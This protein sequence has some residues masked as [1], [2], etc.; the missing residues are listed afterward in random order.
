MY[1]EAEIG[2]RRGW[3]QDLWEPAGV[4]ADEADVQ[5]D[6]IAAEADTTRAISWV[7]QAPSRP[8]EL[9]PIEP[10]GA[11]QPLSDDDLFN[12]LRTPNAREAMRRAREARRRELNAEAHRDPIA[13]PFF[14]TGEDSVIDERPVPLERIPRP[15][16][17]PVSAEE[18]RKHVDDARRSGGD[19]E[20]PIDISFRD[21]DDRF[22]TVPGLTDTPM[23][24]D[25][26]PAPVQD[27]VLSEQRAS[28]TEQDEEAESDELYWDEASRYAP[29][30]PAQDESLAASAD[31]VAETDS[32][33][34]QETEDASAWD[35][36][37]WEQQT[38]W[39]EDD[40]L[41]DPAPQPRP[42]RRGFLG[43]LL[44]RREAAARGE[45]RRD[46]DAR[47]WESQRESDVWPET[48]PWSEREE[49]PAAYTEPAHADSLR[50]E[51]I[52]TRTGDVVELPPFP[53]DTD[54]EGGEDYLLADSV[55]GERD[56]D[57]LGLARMPRICET[58]RYLRP[59]ANGPT[60]GAVYAQTYMR[61]VDL[62]RL[63]CASSIGAW[64]LP[65]DEYWESRVDISHHGDP[66]PLLEQYAIRLEERGT[67]DDLH[68][69]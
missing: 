32:A 12:P 58:C 69:T 38:P 9:E 23:G 34:W 45:L 29:L 35:T 15:I 43:S 67:D 22:T 56:D 52:P 11:R 30:E 54:E 7:N 40:L 25:A 27:E 63:S 53:Y 37:G 33:A 26:P 39:A 47:T 2:C 65:S 60:C 8:A 1:R 20:R 19:F 50:D 36:A 10:K 51:L 31:S 66:T 28:F 14:T 4:D 24:Q 21:D 61:I 18:V 13:R 59:G 46:D 17:P 5:G 49:A 6:R 42:R 44:H 62:Q 48:A 68:T 16:V 55:V 3:K 41:L 64:W 57:D